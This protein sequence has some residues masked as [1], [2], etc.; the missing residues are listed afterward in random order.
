MHLVENVMFEDIM[1]INKPKKYKYTI[2]FESSDNKKLPLLGSYI[3]IY[4]ELSDEQGIN[5]SYM[6]N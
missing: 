6:E 4:A 5:S 3:D 2:N 1:F